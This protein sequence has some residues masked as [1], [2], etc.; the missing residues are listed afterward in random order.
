MEIRNR[1]LAALRRLGQLLPPDFMSV[2]AS[3]LRLLKKRFDKD[4]LTL[5][6]ICHACPESYNVF[7]E[8]EQ[9][10]YLRLRH[11]EFTV[12]A[13]DVGGTLIYYAEPQGDGLFD[14]TERF[15]YLLEALKAIKDD[16]ERT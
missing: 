2:P 12:T 9:V 16:L 6:I 7:R 14:N 8:G 1:Q 15:H 13:P 3:Q 4:G 5:E 11:G 10:A